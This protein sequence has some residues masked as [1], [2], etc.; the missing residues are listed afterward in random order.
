VLALA[1][2]GGESESGDEKAKPVGDVLVGSVAPLAQCR[3][4]AGGSRAERLATIDDVREQVNLKD[5]PVQ[6]EALSDNAAYRIISS[7]CARPGTD[8]LRLYKIYARADAFAAF[9]E[10]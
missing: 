8:G 5:S 9:A 4:W 7:V 6:T 2:C 3:D 1:A 10:K